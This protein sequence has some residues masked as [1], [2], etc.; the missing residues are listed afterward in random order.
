MV[1]AAKMDSRA[2]LFSGHQ[3]CAPWNLSVMLPLLS[4]SG[5]PTSPPG[6][7]SSLASFR[8]FLLSSIQPEPGF[9]A[10]RQGLPRLAPSG[11]SCKTD[12]QRELP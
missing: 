1:L 7:V 3:S 2:T 11:L 9:I 4:K 5:P 6:S 10:C 8:D 12:P